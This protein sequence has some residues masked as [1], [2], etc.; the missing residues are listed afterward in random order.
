[1]TFYRGASPSVVE[2]EITNPLE[3]QLAT[4]ASVK[5]ITSSSIEQGSVITVEFELERDVDEAA[6]EVRDKVSR[7]RGQLPTEAEDPIVSKVDANAQP[8]IWL[9]LTSQQHSLL[10]LSDVADRLLKERLQRVPGVG[11]VFIGAERRYAMRVWLDPSRLAAHQL[12]PQD[13]AQ[14]IAVE[15]VEVPGGLVEGTQREFTVRTR[16][17]LNTAEEFANIIV[18]RTQQGEVRLS[19]VAEV[20]LGAEDE[21]TAARYNGQPA[22]GLGIVKQSK[23]STLDVGRD[24]R[25]ALPELASILPG[26]MTMD[27]AYDSSTFIQESVNEVAQTILI[28]I[29]LVILVVLA[30]L[31]SPRATLIPVVAIPISIVGA[32]V[33]AYF[34]GY[35]INILT[36]LA[37]VL[38]IGIVVDD[39]IVMLENIVRHLEMG[40]GRLRASYDGA[41]EIG[42]AIVATTIALVAVFIPV[43]FLTGTVGRLF[44]EFGIMVAVSVAISGFVALTLSPM[45]C[46]KILRPIHGGGGWAG[47]SFDRFF[48]WV[49]RTYTRILTGSMHHRAITLG[50]A[51]VLVVSAVGVYRIMPRELVPVEDRGIA[52]GIVLAPEGSTLEYT[53]SYM[54]RIE[55]ILLPLP[56]RRALFTATG[57]GFG[58]P[59]RVTNA[60]IFLNLKDRSE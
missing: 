31:K 7:I 5:T 55:E 19:D 1:N 23:A 58:G 29:F 43:S 16:G 11:A 2:T 8:I 35:T 50:V 54:R 52:F 37:L 21:R 44:R 27:V 18:A 39:A 53:D 22:I 15:N 12:T 47:R 40:K 38:A 42:F 9:A 13:I 59:G 33:F 32:F 26:G 14:A 46:S 34:L 3:E 51:L 17:E 49:D 56:E 60:F 10:E 4:L 24:V 25:A 20:A 41:K 48:D 57:L 45:L 28:A 36:L 6:N 30:F